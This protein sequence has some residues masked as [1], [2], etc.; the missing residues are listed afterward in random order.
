METQTPYLTIAFFFILGF[1]AVG[2]VTWFVMI[3]N[4]LVALKN[5]VKKAWADIDVILKQRYEELPNVIAAVKGYMAHEKGVLEGVTEARAKYL[6]APDIHGKLEAERM[7]AAPLKTMFAVAENYPDLKANQN[8]LQLQRRVS[9]LEI[10]I[11]D[12]REL[13]NAAINAFNTRIESLPDVFVAQMLAMRPLELFTASAA[14]RAVPDAGAMLPP[15][16]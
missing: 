8:F 2:L 14:E 7:L 13:Y 4:G 12:R 11:A 3:F 1:A 6:A 15:T 10:E 9:G 16:A 5:D